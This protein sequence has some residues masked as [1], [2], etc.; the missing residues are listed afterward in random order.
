M[1]RKGPL[2]IVKAVP[3]ANTV[4]LCAPTDKPY[5]A[6]SLPPHRTLHFAYIKAPSFQ[7]DGKN[8]D[9]VVFFC[10]FIVLAFWLASS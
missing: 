10:F 4:V 6:A 9:E 2:A 1:N 7:I 8:P 5:N 3:S